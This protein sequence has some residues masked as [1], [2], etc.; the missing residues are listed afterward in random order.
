VVAE[1]ENEQPLPNRGGVNSSNQTPPLVEEGAQFQNTYKCEKNKNVVMVPD[2]ARYQE[3]LCW[4]GPAEIYW[5]GLSLKGACTDTVLQ[6]V[7]SQHSSVGNAM[8]ED[9][10]E[11]VV[12]IGTDGSET[13][14]FH[15]NKSSLE[16]LDACGLLGSR[17]PG[18]TQPLL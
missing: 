18:L 5:A 13:S 4:R 11:A 15:N 14:G 8:W 2:G 1:R 3:R 16:L 6:T 12:R 7:R 10:M 9:H 17:V